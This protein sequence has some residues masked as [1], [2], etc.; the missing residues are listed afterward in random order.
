MRCMLN[1]HV[2]VGQLKNSNNCNVKDTV[3][4]CGY[5]NLSTILWLQTTQTN[6]VFHVAIVAVQF[7]HSKALQSSCN[8]A[9]TVIQQTTCHA[10]VC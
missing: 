8:P 10:L 3:G 9:D 6:S 1:K 4:L 5:P 7:T 2:L